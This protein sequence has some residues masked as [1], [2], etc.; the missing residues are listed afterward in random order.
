MA[1]TI[2][3]FL[4]DNWGIVLGVAVLLVAPY[5]LYYIFRNPF[6]Y[7]YFHMDFNVSRK[8]NVDIID[9]VDRFLCDRNGWR[10]IVDHKRMIEDW[11]DDCESRIDRSVLKRLR[12]KQYCQVLDDE[13]AFKFYTFREQTRYTQTNYVKQAYKTTVDDDAMFFDWYELRNRHERLARI[14]FQATLREYHSKNQRKLMSPELRRM[15]MRRDN[16]TCQICGKYM[17]DE[18]G[19]HIDHIVPIAAGGKSVPSNL[20]VLCSKCNGRKGAR[21]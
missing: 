13:H 14:G 15:I 7:P 8:R 21:Y 17:P 4:R 5:I 20:Q 18:V 1:E 11:K 16:Y 9:Y 19:L 2:V 10:D 3:E 6:Q 12:K